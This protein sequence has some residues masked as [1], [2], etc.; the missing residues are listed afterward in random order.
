[1]YLSSKNLFFV[2]ICDKTKETI[3]NKNEINGIEGR[4]NIVA[5]KKKEDVSLEVKLLI[6]L[7][8]IKYIKTKY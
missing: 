7:F 8:S 2:F 3:P 4:K 5:L 1:L 6:N